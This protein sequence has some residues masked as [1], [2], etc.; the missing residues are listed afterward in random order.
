MEKSNVTMSV[1]LPTPLHE[2]IETMAK[3]DRRSLSAMAC[4]LLEEA[5]NSRRLQA[6]KEKFM[7]E[8]GRLDRVEGAPEKLKATTTEMLKATGG[9]PKQKR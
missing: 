1:R 8:G 4:V 6:G 2:R 7:A 9:K 5:V 3:Q